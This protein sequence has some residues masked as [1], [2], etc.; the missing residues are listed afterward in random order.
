M[1]LWI[2]QPKERQQ[3]QK[4]ASRTTSDEKAS[5]QQRKPSIK[6]KEKIFV[7]HVSDKRLVSKVYKELTPLDNQKP[8][9]PIKKTG[10]GT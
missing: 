3:K 5:A 7:N 10:K 1:I 9:N 2:W 6:W 4:R 8:K